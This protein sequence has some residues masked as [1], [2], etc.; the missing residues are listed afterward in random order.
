MRLEKVGLAAF[1]V[2]T[3]L[4]FAG[5]AASAEEF[6]W[7]MNSI[8]KLKSI[9]NGD[10]HQWAFRKTDGGKWLVEGANFETAAATSAG[11]TGFL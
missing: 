11:G 8:S 6:G 1:L 10:G 3:A 4:L 7:I 2:A 5:S 9:D